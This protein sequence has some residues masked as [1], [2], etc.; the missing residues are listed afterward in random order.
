MK[1]LFTLL[2]ALMLTA[3]GTAAYAQKTRTENDYNLQKAYEVLSEERDEDKGL[4]LVTK[5]LKETP[6]NI[7]ALLLRAKI[8]CN[9]DDYG[10]A[11]KDINHA[12]KVNNPKKSGFENSTLYWWKG[13]IYRD[14]R[15][16]GNACVFL[17]KAYDLSKKDNKEKTNSI[18]FDYAQVL[19]S[20]HQQD[21][22][23][24]I[25]REMLS[26]DEADVA[27]MIGLSRNMINRSQYTEALEML[28]KAQRLDSEYEEVYRFKMQAY[29]K[30][31]E[32]T[33]AI[34]AALEWYDRNDNAPSSILLPICLKRPNYAEAGIKAKVKKSEHVFQW[35]AFLGSFYEKTR[36]W[37]E[38][39]RV[40]DELEAE[41]GHYDEFNEFRSEFYKE[42]GLMDKA[43]SEISVVIDKEPTWDAY[44][45][46]GDYYRLS[47]DLDAAIADFSSAIEE[48]PRISFSY[49]R[50]GWCY[51][52]KGDKKRA[53]E[54]YNLGID[55]NEDYPYLYLLRGT[56]RLEQG[57]RAEAE[58]DF[59]KILQLDTLVEDGS[60][61]MYALHYLGRDK[62][63][64]EWMNRI[65]DAEPENS[66]HYY[67]KACLMARI[68]RLQESVA[69]LRTAF[70]KG[71]RSFAHIRLDDDMDPVR[72]LPEFKALV[73]EYEA[74]QKAYILE[75]KLAGNEDKIAAVTEIPVKRTVSGTFEIPCDINGLQLQ[76][77]FDTGASD[78][79]IS[80]VEANFMLKNG[81]LSE[82]DIKGKRYYQIANGQLSEGPVITLREVKIGDAVL[83]N[84]DASVVKS[85]KAPLLL[86]QSAMERFG[87]ITIDNNSNKL[88]I[89]H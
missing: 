55:I 69:A 15:D 8:Y 51:E 65:I 38:A 71:Y 41:Y 67:D 64:E 83:H 48:N 39:I 60:C 45:K 52:L 49:Y 75:S 44:V 30:M 17:K 10:R 12:I 11:L 61:R 59:K 54:D 58:E 2:S 82:K 25:F 81:Y 4:E 33:K 50:R 86:G 16:Y 29:D 80:S 1:Q 35:K 32:P 26:R 76:M 62:E 18:A 56:L 9:K 53:L 7:E 34:D 77:L 73:T 40:C 28:D 89:K 74:K 70:E 6:D 13:Y 42:L 36:Q 79:T 47:G 27:A 3:M 78:V 43:I 46:R 88:I 63:A 72:D 37:P 21:E 87:T 23:D 31:G 84:V 66:G 14:I 57:N 85:Q 19:Y 68:G 22:S 24:V 5:Q 20:N